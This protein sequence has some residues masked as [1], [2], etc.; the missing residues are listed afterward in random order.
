MSYL[1]LGMYQYLIK[2]CYFGSMG[3]YVTYVSYNKSF[4]QYVNINV[5]LK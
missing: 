2:L 1:C 3:W 5:M 4:F